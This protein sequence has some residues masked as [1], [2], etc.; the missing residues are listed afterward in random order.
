MKV[1]ALMYHDILGEGVAP[2]QSGIQGGPAAR[3]K[4][5]EAQFREQLTLINQKIK[6]RAPLQPG[7]VIGE[8]VLITCDDGGVSAATHAAHILEASGWRG[9][10]FI[11]TDW[12]GKPG[13]L[14]EDQIRDLHRRGHLIGSHSC[15]HPHPFSG[16]PYAQ[17]LAEWRESCARL[18]KII[19]APVCLASV[20]GGAFSKEVAKAAESAG[21]QML[22][23][24]EP[25]HRPTRMG[26]CTILGRYM[27]LNSDQPQYVMELAC[28]SWFATTKL[29]LGWTLRKLAKR[30]GGPLY[31]KLR[32][33]IIHH[34]G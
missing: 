24:S 14:N 10:F 6:D 33:W 17:I 25:N 5:G 27:I 28:G 4:L 20:P 9:Y 18:S 30:V 3:Y 1:S 15:S 31:Y 32:L 7:D 29:S 8:H 26:S 23:T 11:T 16:L 34:R 21:I 19:D 12:I 13:F 22:F 2:D